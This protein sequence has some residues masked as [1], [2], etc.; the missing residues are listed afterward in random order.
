MSEPF[1]STGRRIR[2]AGRR[3]GRYSW[4]YRR[5]KAAAVLQLLGLGEV[6]VLGEVVLTVGLDRA[7]QGESGRAVLERQAQ[8]GQLDLDLVDRLRTEV[9]DVEQVGLAAPDELTHG[10]DALA[11]EAVVRPDREVEVLDRHRERGDVGD[12]G[13]RRADVDALGLVV[14]LA[15]EAE[16]LDQRVAGRCDGVAR[17][18]RVLGLD[19]DHEAVEVGALLDAGGLDVVG[20]LEYGRVDGVDRDAADLLAR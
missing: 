5:P 20:H 16:Q 9:A 3:D 19:V 10:V 2:Y 8:A 4:S 7:R 15:E 17:G 6:L 13:R 14:Q 12:L 18:D 11:L 1:V